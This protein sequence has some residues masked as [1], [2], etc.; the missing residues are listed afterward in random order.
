MAKDALK[1]LLGGTNCT[2][3]CCYTWTGSEYVLAPGSNCSGGP[4]CQSCP[5]Q[6][7]VTNS[8]I[9]RGLVLALGKKCYPTP[10]DLVVSCSVKLENL[11]GILAPVLEQRRLVNRLT[12]LTA[13]LGAV[14]FLLLSGLIFTLLI[15]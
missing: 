15:R 8:Q 9:L 6:P 5:Q 3:N 1:E 13:A 12:K 2:G 14:S 11:T 4:N 10:D 7:G